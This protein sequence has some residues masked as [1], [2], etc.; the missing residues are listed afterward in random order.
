MFFF[1]EETKSSQSE[2]RSRRCLG[3]QNLFLLSL[4]GL[5]FLSSSFFLLTSARRVCASQSH[6]KINDVSFLFPFLSHGVLWRRN[7]ACLCES[8]FSSSS[9]QLPA[10]HFLFFYK[11]V[12]VIIAWSVSNRGST[13]PFITFYRDQFAF[14][15]VEY[16]GV[17]PEWHLRDLLKGIPLKKSQSELM[18]YPSE[19]V[20]NHQ[21][22]Q[23]L[24]EYTKRISS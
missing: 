11:P 10:T 3:L 16:V 24:H 21:C 6:P 15:H 14:Q 8:L 12:V 20:G 17:V 9:K 18:R 2:N 1:L 4:F 5:V 22:L 23:S 13:H 19:S 7:H